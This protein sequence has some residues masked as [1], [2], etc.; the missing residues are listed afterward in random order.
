MKHFFKG[1]PMSNE[2]LARLDSIQEALSAVDRPLSF[3]EAAHYLSVSRSHMYKLTHR[4]LIP[5]FKPGGKKLYFTRRDL[6]S[7]ILQKPIKTRAAIEQEATDH[8]SIRKAA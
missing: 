2:I 6:D 7:F 5:C 1:K 8:V 3:N 4:R